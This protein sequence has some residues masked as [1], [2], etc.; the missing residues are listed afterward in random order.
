MMT[1]LLKMEGYEV[2]AYQIGEDIINSVRQ[3]NPDA[4]LMDVY[5]NT[6]QSSADPVGLSILKEIRED[7]KISETKVIMTS[8][9]DFH[10][11]SQELGADGFLQK[12]YMPE[13]LLGLIR[14]V[15]T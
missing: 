14:Q 15:L 5:L 12:P 8:G 1:S 2:I 11:D 4:I 6:S 7:P 13:D 3:K 9:I 10:I